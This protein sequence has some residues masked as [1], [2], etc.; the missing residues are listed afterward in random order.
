M[1]RCLIRTRNTGDHLAT[2]TRILKFIF[3]D[4]TDRRSPRKGVWR[5]GE[6][7][8]NARGACFPPNDRKMPHNRTPFLPLCHSIVAL[9]ILHFAMVIITEVTVSRRFIRFSVFLLVF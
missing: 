5:E 3:N 7:G 1:G 6:K 2:I 9:P 4:R 8:K